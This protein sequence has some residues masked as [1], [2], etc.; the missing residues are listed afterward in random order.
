MSR[1]SS[2][3]CMQNDFWAYGKSSANHAPILHWHLH[4]LQKE[5]SKISNDPCHL[6]VPSAASK[7]IYE[8]HHPVVP[9]GESKMTFKPMV[10]LA[11]TM[12]LSCTDTHT[13]TKWKEERFHMAHATYEFHRM[14]PKQFLSLWYVRRKPCTYLWPRLALSLNGPSFHL[15]LIISIGCV[16][17]DVCADGTFGANCATIL[18]IH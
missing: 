2:I 14:C 3:G 9:S 16:Q 13:V 18:H 17:N 12:H 7:T 8:P 6:G 10:R 5:R 11:Q 4:Y 1:R 15:S